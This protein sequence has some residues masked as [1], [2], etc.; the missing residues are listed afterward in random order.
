MSILDVLGAQSIPADRIEIVPTATDLL[1]TRDASDTNDGRAISLAN[2]FAHAPNIKGL[3]SA[4][5]M[6]GTLAEA[7]SGKNLVV[8]TD[9][10][11]ITLPA[12]VVGMTFTLTNGG[13]DGA[14][15]LKIAPNASDKIMGNGYTSADNKYVA[16]TKATAKKGDFIVLVGDGVNGWFI[17]EVRG[18]WAKEA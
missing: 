15:L 5:K 11:T 14:V 17:Q 9:A 4:T 13:A 8:D 16:N 3:I 1:E 2:I 18:I 7:D 12:T 10:Q 6:T